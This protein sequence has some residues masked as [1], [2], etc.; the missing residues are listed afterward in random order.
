MKY[1]VSYFQHNN[2]HKNNLQKA[3]F[4]LLKIKDRKLIEFDEM[5]KFEHELKIEV[6]NLNKKYN[7]C[8]PIEVSFWKHKDICYLNSIDN[9][10]FLLIECEG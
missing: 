3:F 2:L 9:V 1:Y 8:T 10:S 5:P 6:E 4:E 7:R